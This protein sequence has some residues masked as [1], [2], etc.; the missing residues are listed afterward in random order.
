MQYKETQ[1][2]YAALS[3]MQCNSLQ[4]SGIEDSEIKFSEVETT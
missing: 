4:Y 3:F 1:L 2:H